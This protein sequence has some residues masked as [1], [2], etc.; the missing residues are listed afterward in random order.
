MAEAETVVSRVQVGAI[1][2]VPDADVVAAITVA[3]LEAWPKPSAEVSPEPVN[4]SWR[5]SQR[6]WRGRSIP[7]QTWGR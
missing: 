2:P 5:F 1:S 6:R 4:V 7:R 3:V